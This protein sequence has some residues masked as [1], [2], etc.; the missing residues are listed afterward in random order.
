MKFNNIIRILLI[1]FYLVFTTDVYAQN[2]DSK[3]LIKDLENSSN[4][5]FTEYLKIYDDYLKQNP[6]DITIQ[7]EKCKFLQN[8]QYNEMDESNP[9][10]EAADSCCAAL[11]KAY[12]NHPEV[13]IFQT[14]YQWGDEL[15]NVFAAAQASIKTNPKAWSDKNLGILYKSMFD[16]SFSDEELQ[17]AYWYMQEAISKDAEYKYTLENARILIKMKK[18]KEALNVLLSMKDTTEQLW[19]LTQKADMLLE[20]KAYQKALDIYNKISKIDSSYNNNRNI[21]NV[22]E[23]VGQVDLARKCLVSDTAMHWQKETSRRNLLLHDLKYQNASKCIDSYNKYRDLGISSDPLGIYRLKVFFSHPLQSWTFRDVLAMLLL[24]I[25]ILHL[26][27]I[28]YIWILPI[29]FIGHKWNFLSR[30]KPFESDWGLKSFW[31]ISFGFLLASFI[32]L[33]VDPELLSYILSYSDYEPELNQEKS[34]L[35]TVVF[36]LVL[37]FFGFASLYKTNLKTLLSSEWS[38]KKSILWSLGILVLYRIISVIYIRIGV[39]LFDV[40]IDDLA[41]IPQ[42]FLTTRQEIEALIA[43]SGKG[44]SFLLI[45]LLVPI[46]EE[47][48]FRGI[49]LGSCQRYT[50]FQIANFIQATLFAAVHVNLFLFPV[51]LS[52]GIITGILRKKSGGLLGGIVFH[53]FNNILAILLLLFK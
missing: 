11:A 45:C 18:E 34:G 36:V 32:T 16:Q 22:L 9:N 10:Q 24:V 6:T 39:N 53:I 14:T 19:K 5:L 43:F 25:V 21:A 51:F 52:F 28:P 27:L 37:A 29:Y 50:N 8:A 7:I 1:L 41:S 38:I 12:P 30:A 47:I 4:N 23:E 46:Y 26:V 48:I 42:L 49:I 15:K 13:L 17:K 3:I 33:F 2:L 40:S 20:L 44:I 35:S 31:F